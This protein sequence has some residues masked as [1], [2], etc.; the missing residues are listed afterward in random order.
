MEMLIEGFDEE[1][2]KKYKDNDEMYLDVCEWFGIEC[3]DGAIIIEIDIDTE[4]VRGSLAVCYAPP[5]VQ[6]LAIGSLGRRSEL[7]GSVDLT[8]LPIELKILRLNNN[9]FTGEI[10]LF[11]MDQTIMEMLIDG[12]D[13]VTKEEYQ[14]YDGQFLDVCEWSCL[15]CDND[16]RAI[17]ILIDSRHIR[18]GEDVHHMFSM[19]SDRNNDA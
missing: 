6:V 13:D 5:K 7:T 15:E 9:R 4:T 19:N 11:Y 2:K 17:G 18:V 1:A 12:F 8:Q 14:E 10:D 16:A 3:D